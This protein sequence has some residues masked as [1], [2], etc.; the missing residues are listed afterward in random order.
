ML[1]AGSTYT[2]GDGL[3]TVLEIARRVLEQMGSSLALDVRGEA[4]NEIPRQCLSA[5]KAKRVL[6]WKPMFDLDQGMKQTVAWYRSFFGAA[7]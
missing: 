5:A 2:F 3:L 7:Q 6:G 1:V 4:T